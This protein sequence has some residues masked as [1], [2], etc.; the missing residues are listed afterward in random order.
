MLP[1]DLFDVAREALVL[2]LLLSIPILGAALVAGL[3]TAALQTLTRVSEPA[4]THVPRI[5][6]V[7]AAVLIAAPWISARVAGFAD[8]VWS[9]VHAVGH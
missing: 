8:R 6:A 9:L 2:V 7:A 3:A 1:V 4:L 5:V